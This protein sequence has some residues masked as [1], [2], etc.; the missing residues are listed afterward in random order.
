MKIF[1]QFPFIVSI[2][3]LSAIV[4]AAFLIAQ[5]VVRKRFPH[6][7]LKENHEVGGYIFNAVGIIYAVLIAF[8]VF[9][10]W[11]NLKET[12]SKIELEASKLTDLYYDAN[13]YPDSIKQE[14]QK[15]IRDYV[16][17]V[18][19]SEWDSM[20][21]GKS[22]QE[23]LKSYIKLNRIFLSIKSNQL[24][25]EQMLSQSLK[26]LNDLRESRRHRLLSSHQNM[27][28]ILWLVL[29][30]SSVILIVFT[31][32]FSTINTWHQYIM[33]AFLVFVNVLVLYLIYV[34]DHPFIGQYGLKPDAFDP[35]VNIIKN[36]QK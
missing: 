6:E 17:R 7:K 4:I 13:V 16:L 18:T 8:I 29:I 11:S 32:F 24:P 9:V 1:L 5:K 30:I 35:L 19:T 3:I 25:N 34:L 27:P 33:T 23:A 15:T 20:K 10:I 12:D 14:I 28:D 2:I 36:L 22:D 31:F 21:E 26:N